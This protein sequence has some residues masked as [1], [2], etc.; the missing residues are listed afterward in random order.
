M[1]TITLIKSAVSK[2]AVRNSLSGHTPDVRHIFI[3]NAID[4]LN[5]EIE[6]DIIS[7]NTDI[8][9]FKMSQVVMLEDERHIVERVL[10]KTVVAP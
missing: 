10:L 1:T 2:E 5:K 3:T 7:G 4:S 9:I 6:Q 8:A